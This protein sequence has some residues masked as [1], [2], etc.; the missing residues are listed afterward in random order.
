MTM[1]AKLTL[2]LAV[3]A[4]VFSEAEAAA[5][6][7]LAPLG[8]GIDG[9][10]SWLSHHHAKD[11]QAELQDQWLAGF[12][13]GYNAFED[14]RRR[15]MSFFRFDLATLPS[16]VTGQCRARP[17]TDVYTATLGFL[18][19]LGDRARSSGNERFK[20]PKPREHP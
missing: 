13:T 17:D 20:S 2:I 3:G 6:K 7:P 18:E 4:C 12:V 16:G 14:P 9:C 11:R 8:M 19:A 15:A 10:R 1:R 5:P